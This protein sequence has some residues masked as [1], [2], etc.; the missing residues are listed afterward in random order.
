MAVS[1]QFQQKGV[2]KVVYKKVGQGQKERLHPDTP[3]FGHAFEGYKEET[4][5]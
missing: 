1:G 2:E 5:E 3:T 4:A